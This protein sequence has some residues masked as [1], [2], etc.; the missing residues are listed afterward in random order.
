MPILWALANPKIWEREVLQAMM[1]RDG[2]LI[3]KPNEW[4]EAAHGAIWA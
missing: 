1:D 4:D 3:A 2:D